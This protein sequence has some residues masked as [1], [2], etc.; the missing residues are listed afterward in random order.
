[1]QKIS[2]AWICGFRIWSGYRWWRSKPP[3]PGRAAVEGKRC[4]GAAIEEREDMPTR[5][6]AAAVRGVGQSY[7]NYLYL[8]FT[9]KNAH[10]LQW[11]GKS[12]IRKGK[13]SLP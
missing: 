12:F 6:L 13:F 3:C 4:G 1:M 7:S 2:E 9:R 11:E 10:A 5:R 8:L